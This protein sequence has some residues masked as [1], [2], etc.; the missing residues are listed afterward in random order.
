MYGYIDDDMLGAN[1]EK[2]KIPWSPP[3][4]I[5]TLF[6]ELKARQIFATEDNHPIKDAQAIRTGVHIVKSSRLLD[7]ACRKRR[8]KTSASRT[9]AGFKTYSSLAEQEYHSATTTNNSGYH[10]ANAAIYDPSS[11]PS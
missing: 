10:N 1:I 11:L 7:L 4:S 6:T 3:T 2:M 9:T 5:K 8:A